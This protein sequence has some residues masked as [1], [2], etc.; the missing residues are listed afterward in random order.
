MARD[1][2]VSVSSLS[3]QLPKGPML[4]ILKKKMPHKIDR[5]VGVQS[6]APTPLEVVPE[7]VQLRLSDKHLLTAAPAYSRGPRG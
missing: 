5:N 1:D 2:L 6:R 4:Y 3:P 7:D